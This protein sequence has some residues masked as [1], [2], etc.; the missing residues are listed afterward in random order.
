MPIDCSLRL[1]RGT[2]IEKTLPK[3]LSTGGAG[4]WIGISKHVPEHDRFYRER[5][6][7]A[8][9]AR[10]TVRSVSRRRTSSP[11]GQC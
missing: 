2:E 7:S 4:G 3:T 5:N 8:N 1:C 10:V 11:A 6:P 9:G